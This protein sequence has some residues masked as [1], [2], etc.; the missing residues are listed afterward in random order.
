[1]RLLKIK[2]NMLS[3]NQKYNQPFIDN[4]RLLYKFQ[5]TKTLYNKIC[6]QLESFNNRT[7]KVHLVKQ[8][9]R[10]E[11]KLKSMEELIKKIIIENKEEME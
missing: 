11:E 10:L 1:M 9:E 6:N 4:V 8:K 7:S 3:E 5:T 2:N